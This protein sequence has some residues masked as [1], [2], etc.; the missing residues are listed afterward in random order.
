[1]TI[2]MP[3]DVICCKA[4]SSLSLLKFVSV[5]SRYDYPLSEVAEK[6]S[7]NLDVQDCQRKIPGDDSTQTNVIVYNHV[8]L[9]IKILKTWFGENTLLDQLSAH[10]L[11]DSLQDFLVLLR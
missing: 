5:P 1:M 7:G 2:V 10:A 4:F 8:N 9:L 11:C 6:E 3:V